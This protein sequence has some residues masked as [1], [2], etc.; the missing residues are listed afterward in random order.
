[1]LV[2]YLHLPVARLGIQG[3]VFASLLTFLLLW[4]VSSFTK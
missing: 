1:L 3:E 2:N 4:I